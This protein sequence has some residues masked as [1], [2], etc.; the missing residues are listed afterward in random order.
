[1]IARLICWLI[2]H[3][4]RWKPFYSPWQDGVRY[5]HYFRDWP[6]VW[7]VALVLSLPEGY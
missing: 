5:L 6:G 3:N 1:M 4:F 2:G 7:S